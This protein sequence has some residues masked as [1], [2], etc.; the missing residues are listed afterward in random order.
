MNILF[1]FPTPC[2]KAEVVNPEEGHIV[3]EQVT[4]QGHIAEEQTQGLDPSR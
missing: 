2:E 1:N 4:D 3:E